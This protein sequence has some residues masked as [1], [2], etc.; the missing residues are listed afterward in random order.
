MC[1]D[2]RGRVGAIEAV[3]AIEELGECTKEGRSD[4]SVAVDDL[5]TLERGCEVVVLL[6]P[7]HPYWPKARE[8]SA[9]HC[10]R[11][12]SV[13]SKDG[14]SSIAMSENVIDSGRSTVGERCGRMSCV[15]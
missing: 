7:S 13:S 14:I 10:R 2:G 9:S 6:L 8:C 5:S 12:L 4:E 1:R 3:E 15:G 11:W